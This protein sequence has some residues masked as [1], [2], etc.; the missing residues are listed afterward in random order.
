M[1][2]KDTVLSYL[3]VSNQIP[4]TL[5][6]FVAKLEKQADASFKAGIKEMVEWFDIHRGMPTQ[7]RHPDSRRYYHFEEKDWQAKLKEWGIDV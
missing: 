4:M 1:K 6:D 3:E 5:L 7:K 2:A